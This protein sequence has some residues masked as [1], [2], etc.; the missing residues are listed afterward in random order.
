MVH[1][2]LDWDGFFGTTQASEDEVNAVSRTQGSGENTY[3]I[4]AGKPE[5]KRQLGRPRGR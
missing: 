1:R 2:A 5:R 4:L 3:R